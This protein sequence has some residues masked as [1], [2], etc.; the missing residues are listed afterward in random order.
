MFVL[1]RNRRKNSSRVRAVHCKDGDFSKLR[2]LATEISCRM[3]REFR[4]DGV[5]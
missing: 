2:G 1:I 5:L 4:K 3:K